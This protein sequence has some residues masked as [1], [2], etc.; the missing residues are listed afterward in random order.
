MCM[1]SHIHPHISINMPIDICTCIDFYAD[2]YHLCRKEVEGRVNVEIMNVFN[3]KLHECIF[4][5]K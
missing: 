4:K 1:N 3:C 5:K 2:M